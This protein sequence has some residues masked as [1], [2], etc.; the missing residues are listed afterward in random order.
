M[1]D[2]FHLDAPS[3][4]IVRLAPVSFAV[5]RM[6]SPAE[7]NR[8]AVHA[9]LGVKLPP[10]G[11]LASA[12]AGLIAG[13]APGEWALIGGSWYLDKIAASAS[14]SSL[15]SLVDLT[16]GQVTW[17]VAGPSAGLLLSKGCTLDFHPRS[18]KQGQVAQSALAQTF[19]TILRPDSDDAF[20]V[21]AERSYAHHLELW[22][23]DAIAEFS[24]PESVN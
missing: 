5:L 23:R 14:A 9:E 15:A 18:F 8:T 6:R 16:K 13:T 3:V 17:R 20:Q 1:S 4:A 10:V 19:V 11:Q 21:I 12:Q 2:L 24:L 7:K 22:F